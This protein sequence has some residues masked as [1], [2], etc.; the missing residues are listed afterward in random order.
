L[1]WENLNEK[2]LE[3][4]SQSFRNF[5]SLKTIGFDFTC[6]ISDSGVQNIVEGLNYFVILEA[7]TFKFRQENHITKAQREKM[8]KTL[9]NHQ[10]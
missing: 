8:I 4:I 7:V 9:K 10:S 2:K 1:S 6:R 5:A 3:K